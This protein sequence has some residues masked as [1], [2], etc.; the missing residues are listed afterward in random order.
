[1]TDVVEIATERRA[2]LVAEIAEL[3]DFVGMAKKLLLIGGNDAENGHDSSTLNLFAD[4][5]A[6]H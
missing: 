4:T 6:R 2:K 3:D 5:K 1:M